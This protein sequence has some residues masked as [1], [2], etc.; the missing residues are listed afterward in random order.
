MFD[1]RIDF[2][3]SVAVITGG[4]RGI[5][6]GIAMALARAGARVIINGRDE[7]A[8]AQVVCTIEKAGGSAYAIAG[9]VTSESNVQA[10]RNEVERI[11]GSASLLV[12]CAG[13][14]GG[15]TPLIEENAAHWRA[16]LEVNLTSAF[17]TLRAF[18]P[19]MIEAKRGAIVTIASSAGRQISGSSAA[20]AAAKAGLLALTRQAAVEAA[21]HGVRINSIAPSAIVTDRLAVTPLSVRNQMAAAFPM[22]R[23]GEIEDVAQAALFLLNERSSWITGITLD[24]AGGRVML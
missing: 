8:L 3:G 19:Q 24:V 14:D 7:A 5:G 13:G 2:T 9:D 23:L 22:R 4:S 18:L 6:A 10:L 16:V 12:A 17:L 21:P 1:N 11:F 20:Y 15:P